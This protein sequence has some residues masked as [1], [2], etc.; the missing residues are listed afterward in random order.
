MFTTTIDNT[1]SKERNQPHNPWCTECMNDLISPEEISAVMCKFCI[2][3]GG[4]A[5][6]SEEIKQMGQR[7]WEVVAEPVQA[8]VAPD[9]GNDVRV[10]EV[11]IGEAV[12]DQERSDKKTETKYPWQFTGVPYVLGVNGVHLSDKAFRVY[13]MLAFH[14]NLETGRI[15][16]S[17]ETLKRETSMGTTSIKKALKELEA[18]GWIKKAQRAAQKGGFQSNAYTL[19]TPSIVTPTKEEAVVFKKANSRK[20]FSRG[21]GGDYGIDAGVT[22]VWVHGGPTN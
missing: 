13:S 7:K 22:T 11:V 3:R 14:R 9:V 12:T 2:G 18:F 20:Y 16:P 8:E 21:R 15:F 1:Q 10:E 17:I 5:A 6:T 4:R 19:L